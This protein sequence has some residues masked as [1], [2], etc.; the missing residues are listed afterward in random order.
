MFAM[1]EFNFENV[2]NTVREDGY[3]AKAKDGLPKNMELLRDADPKQLAS[4][5]AYRHGIVSPE[6]FV[7]WTPGSLLMPSPLK[8][9]QALMIVDRGRHTFV[10]TMDGF[11]VAKISRV[12]HGSDEPILN[13]GKS[14]IL[15]LSHHRIGLGFFAMF[16]ISLWTSYQE[17]K[18]NA[19]MKRMLRK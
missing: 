1:S 13:H 14:I 10:E 12:E 6:H 4:F 11:K 9:Y 3:Y 8:K 7:L 2:C 5:V 19:L 17:S 18:K 16:F 15:N